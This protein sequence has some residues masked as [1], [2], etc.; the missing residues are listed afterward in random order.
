MAQRIDV[1]CPGPDNGYRLGAFIHHGELQHTDLIGGT[2]E[3]PEAFVVCAAAATV[4]GNHGV[5]I[6]KVI[7]GAASA[8]THTHESTPEPAHTRRTRPRAR[9]TFPSVPQSTV[10]VSMLHSSD[11]T[12]RR[13]P[14]P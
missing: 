8:E 7:R 4:C 12:T 9:H 10:G 13:W 11:S 5:L 14:E 3:Y 6:P 2:H 1:L